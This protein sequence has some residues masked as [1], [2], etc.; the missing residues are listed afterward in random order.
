MVL[1]DR[2]RPRP[3]QQGEEEGEKSTRREHHDPGSHV[4]MVQAN[5]GFW[6]LRSCRTRQPVGSVPVSAEVKISSL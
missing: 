2:V 6:Q 4:Q 5:S 1:L 3:D